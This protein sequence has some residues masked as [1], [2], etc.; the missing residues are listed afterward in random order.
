MGSLGSWLIAKRTLIVL[1][2]TVTRVLTSIV[3]AL[4]W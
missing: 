3:A 4:S 2:H 1:N